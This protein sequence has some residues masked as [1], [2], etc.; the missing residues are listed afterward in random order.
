M[1]RRPGGMNKLRYMSW[2]SRRELKIAEWMLR[3]V[4]ASPTR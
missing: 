4:T 2:Q 3:L 1:R